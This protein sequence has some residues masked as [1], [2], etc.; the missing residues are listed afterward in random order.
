VDGL[1]LPALYHVCVIVYLL[2]LKCFINASVMFF[3]IL[4]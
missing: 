1:A 2:M 4:M 3:D